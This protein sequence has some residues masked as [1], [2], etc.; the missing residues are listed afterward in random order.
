MVTEIVRY[1]IP[2]DRAEA[3]AAAYTEAGRFLADSPH[4]LGYELLRGTDEPE[5]WVLLI[6][7]ASVGAHLEGF[8]LAPGF[9]EFLRLVMPFFAAIQEM[10][11]YGPTSVL[12]A[13]AN[14][15]G[16]GGPVDQGAVD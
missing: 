8:R 3:F 14:P 5:N 7:W 4:C 2:L 10:K 15:L 13:P 11:H 6:R 16:Q 1:R 12:W 9:G